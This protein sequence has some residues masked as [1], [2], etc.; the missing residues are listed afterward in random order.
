M[1]TLLTILILLSGLSVFSQS[2]QIVPHIH[3]GG[4]FTTGKLRSIGLSAT[5]NPIWYPREN[6]RFG[7]GLY[8]NSNVFLKGTLETPVEEIDQPFGTRGGFGI[9][10]RFHFSN[11]NTRP[12]VALHPAYFFVSSFA[13]DVPNPVV[14]TYKEQSFGVGL[15]LGLVINR[16]FEISTLFN[17]IPENHSLKAD[18]PTQSYN[19]PVLPSYFCIN[20]GVTGIPRK[21]R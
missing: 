10:T 21:Q 18:Y 6:R 17:Y 3:F 8:L 1:R 15:E 14:Q 9:S 20:L 7:L 11:S 4:A 16:Y 19:I 12:F 13:E 5:L 2:N